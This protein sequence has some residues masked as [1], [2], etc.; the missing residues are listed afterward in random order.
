MSLNCALHIP[1]FSMLGASPM[2]NIGT[3]ERNV[4]LA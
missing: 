3:Q 4:F 1:R 2:M